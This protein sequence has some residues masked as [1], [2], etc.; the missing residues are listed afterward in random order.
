MPVNN[1]EKITFEDVAGLKEVKEEIEFKVLNPLKNPEL[2]KKYKDYDIA[3]VCKYIA[4]NQK[5][6]LKFPAEG[7]LRA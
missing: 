2:A 5:Q 4:P 7:L 1:D 3:I 6:R